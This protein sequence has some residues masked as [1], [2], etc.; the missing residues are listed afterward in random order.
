MILSHDISV[1]SFLSHLNWLLIVLY[2]ILLTFKYRRKASCNQLK[3]D[4][5]ECMSS[6]LDGGMDE[7]WAQAVGCVYALAGSMKRSC[8]FPPEADLIL[9]A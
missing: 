3:T 4:Q 2:H 8:D 1:L 5:S 6:I 9:S 7:L